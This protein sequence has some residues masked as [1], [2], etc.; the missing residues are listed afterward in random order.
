MIGNNAYKGFS[1]REAE[2]TAL[3]VMKPSE[4][5][6]LLHRRLTTP[7]AATSLR[8]K[9]TRDRLIECRVL[10]VISSHFLCLLAWIRE[11]LLSVERQL[12]SLLKHPSVKPLA[13][14]ANDVLLKIYISYQAH[15]LFTYP[16]AYLT[17]RSLKTALWTCD[18]F[19]RAVLNLLIPL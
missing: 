15:S 14:Q 10:H 7:F 18:L 6:E 19:E 4:S 17:A 13:R 9:I 12:M 3:V 1:A 2:A 5:R 11:G 8:S 16:T